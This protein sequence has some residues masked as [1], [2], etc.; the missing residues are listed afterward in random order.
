[1]TLYSLR[2]GFN[3]AMVNSGLSEIEIRT[4]TGHSNVAMTEHYT[5][6]TEKNLIRQAEARSQVLPFI[7]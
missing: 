3:T 4:V 2:H 5:H 1:M 7:E 6:E